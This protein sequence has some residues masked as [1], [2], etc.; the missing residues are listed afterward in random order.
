MTQSSTYYHHMRLQFPLVS[1]TT[2]KNILNYSLLTS[3]GTGLRFPS[4]YPDHCV[5]MSADLGTLL[6]QSARPALFVLEN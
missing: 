1:G 5:C 4:F 3:I 6:G 2:G